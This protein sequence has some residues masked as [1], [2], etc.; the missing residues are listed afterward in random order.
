MH[1]TARTAPGTG[2]V[3]HPA[4]ALLTAVVLTLLAAPAL[5]GPAATGVP[6][7]GMA[8]TAAHHRDTGPR[9]DEGC[10]TA[11]TV[12]A[13]TRQEP[14]REHPAPRCQ[15]ATC[16]QGTAVTPPGPARHST[17]TTHA[18]AVEPHTPHDRGRAPP[19][20]SGI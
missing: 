13:A 8:A 6:T 2:S 12:R 4:L 19:D 5:T 1:R 15:P 18:S 16:A 9:A 20:L 17:Q 11:C 10:D 7:A 3:R 14:H